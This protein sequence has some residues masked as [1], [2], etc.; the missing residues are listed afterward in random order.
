M[1]KFCQKLPI[2]PY[3]RPAE[4]RSELCLCAHLAA[5]YLT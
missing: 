2:D 1:G 4:Y 5:D 3:L